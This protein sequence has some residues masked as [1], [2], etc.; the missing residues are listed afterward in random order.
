MHCYDCP[1]D[2]HYPYGTAFSCTYNASKIYAE[3]VHNKCKQLNF[4]HCLHGTCA[5]ESP[6]QESHSQNSAVLL[7]MRAAQPIKG[8]PANKR[9]A[10]AALHKVM[11]ASVAKRYQS[12]GTTCT[13]YF[14]Y[15]IHTKRVIPFGVGF[16]F[17]F[18]PLILLHHPPTL[19]K[20]HFPEGKGN[21]WQ[22]FPRFQ[23]LDNLSA[24]PVVAPCITMTRKVLGRQSLH[25]PHP[26]KTQ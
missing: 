25:L 10:R 15:L 9:A 22:K 6:Y 21:L 19:Q 16:S 4:L 23:H 12:T 8:K 20:F 13:G 7:L 17:S 5:P 14:S 3:N 24:R 11:T 1:A 2:S 18:Y 26:E